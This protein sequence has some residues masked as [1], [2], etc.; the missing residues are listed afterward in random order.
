MEHLRL[1]A[2]DPRVHAEALFDLIAKT[3]SDDGGYYT[4]REACRRM[5]V[6]HSHYDWEASRIGLVGDRLVTHYGVWKYQMRIGAARVPVGGIGAVATD[7]DFRRRGLMDL[8]ANASLEA[9]RALGYD[10]TTLFGIDSFYHRF[11]YVRAW[12]DTTYY[13]R[14]PDLPTEPPAARL[15]RFL[16]HPRPDLA[17]L[18]NATFSEATGTAVRPT[19]R[20]GHASWLGNT[21]GYLWRAQGQPAGYVALT[22]NGA[23]LRCLEYAGD[24]YQALCAVA[25][26]ARQWGCQEIQFATLPHRS[27]L[28]RMLRWNSCRAETLYRRNG[29]S[30]IAVLNLPATLEKLQ[31]ELSRR[32]QA[33]PLAA[34]RG[35][36]LLADAREQVALR[37]ARGHV[38]LAPAAES[39]HA[40]RGGNAMA[41]FLLGTEAPAEVIAAG[42]MKVTGDAAKLAEVLFPAQQPQLSQLDRY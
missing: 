32:L 18:Y 41:Q 26:L 2:P 5:Y 8:T 27:E 21:E 42:G 20:R 33:S 7:P 9:M 4:L 1:I 15:H 28:V 25:K 36:L 24:A 30:M 6:Q 14:L 38:R 23:Q 29:G 19:F 40:L 39:E 13:V 16:P 35:T 34:W 10:L 31:D 3:F 22:R 12:S 17:A 37:L 11:G